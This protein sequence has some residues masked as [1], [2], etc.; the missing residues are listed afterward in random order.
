MKIGPC[1]PEPFGNGDRRTYPQMQIL[2]RIIAHFNPQQLRSRPNANGPS[3]EEVAI[4]TRLANFSADFSGLI[5]LLNPNQD[6]AN[7]VSLEMA[8]WGKCRPILRLSCQR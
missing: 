8:R 3:Y 2:L 5:G 7:V 4:P 6:M 1:S